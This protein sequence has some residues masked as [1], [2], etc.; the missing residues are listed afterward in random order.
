MAG[1]PP[2]APRFPDR[3]D[4]L[5]R[6]VHPHAGQCRPGSHDRR[7]NACSLELHSH[8]TPHCLEPGLRRVV[9]TH[10]WTL[11]LGTIRAAQYEV[12][13]LPFTHTGENTMRQHGRKTVVQD[14]K[15]LE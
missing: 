15:W 3:S 12:T 7:A 10:E 11:A 4:D 13:A 6:R 5:R 9:P 8:L 14:T 2:L 1:E